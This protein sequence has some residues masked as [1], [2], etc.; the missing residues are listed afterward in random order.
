[1]PFVLLKTVHMRENLQDSLTSFLMYR[2]QDPV[3]IAVLIE[4]LLQG[5][6]TEG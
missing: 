1:M 2:L 6:H 4:E 5:R 3:P